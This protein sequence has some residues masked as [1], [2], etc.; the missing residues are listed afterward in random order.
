MYAVHEQVAFA[1]MVLDVLQVFPNQN[2]AAHYGLMD[3]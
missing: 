1:F 2:R 3:V